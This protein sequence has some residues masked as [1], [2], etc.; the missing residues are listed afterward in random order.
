[1][2]R[3]TFD[4]EKI[5]KNVNI[6]LVA[7]QISENVGLTARVLKN[8]S[9]SSLSLVTP[10]ISKKSWEVAKRAQ[11][12]L[13]KAH[14]FSNIEAAISDSSFVFGTTRRSR[15][16]TP[17]YSF[18]LIVPQLVS[19]AS[20]RKVSILFGKE[21]FGLSRQELALCDSIFYIPANPKFSSYNL[22]F[23]VGIVCYEI[24]NFLENIFSFG[25]MELAKNRDLHTLRTFIKKALNRK[26]E[27]TMTDSLLCSLERAL[28][29]THLTKKE[30][31]ILK[32]I[33]I[34]LQ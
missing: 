25:E 34:K 28:K 6:V 2:S 32:T 21:N 1:M 20:R 31:E 24:F 33:F 9:F 30:V 4:K 10:S 18:N 15:K 22:A 19:L 14:I 13:K 8:T 27:S 16:Y 11:D 26:F 12:L 17:I 23:S 29:R 7:P 3:L 5:L